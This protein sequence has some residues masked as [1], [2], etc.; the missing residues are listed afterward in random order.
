MTLFNTTH[1]FIVEGIRGMVAMFSHKNFRTNTPAMRN[2]DVSKRNIYIMYLDDNNLYG[3]MMSQSL[4][5]SNFKWFTDGEM[6]EIDVIMVPDDG[7]RG[8]I[9][10]CDL[11]K[12]YF[13]YFHIYIYFIKC[14]ILFLS[15]SEYL[16]YV[17]KSNVSFLCIINYPLELHDLH[18]DY[19]LTLERF[20]IE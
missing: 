19:T 10:E 11:G 1:L 12:Y 16:R 8:Y 17:I 20:Q 2:Y 5:T 15:I 13:Y 6:E 7:S 18:N 9:L 3:W 4:P 14:N